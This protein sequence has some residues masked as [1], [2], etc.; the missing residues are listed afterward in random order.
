MTES[1][2]R[3][4]IFG[5]TG[6][7]GSYLSR[8]LLQQGYQVH[9]TSRDCAPANLHRLKHLNVLQ[10]V[11]VHKVQPTNMKIVAKVIE[12]VRPTEIYNLA[13]ES[14]VAVSFNKPAETLASTIQ[15]TVNMLEGMRSVGLDA[16]FYNAA[17]SECYG[18]T[19]PQG[20]D[21]TT[22]FSPRSPYGVGKAAAFWAVK[23][24]RQ[25]Y[26][27]FACSGILFNHESPL[28]PEWFVSQKIVRG[29]VDISLKNTDYL[30]LGDLTVARDWGWAPEYMEAVAKML[31]LDEPDDF[32]VAT[33][34]MARLETLVDLVFSYLNL[35]WTDHVISNPTLRRPTDISTSLGKPRKARR[36]LGWK[37]RVLLDEIV[38][39]LVEGELERRRA[40]L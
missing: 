16:K 1:D 17:S 20:A 28:R 33:G 5:I 36:V 26:N 24:Y 29:A 32:V 37:A 8:H 10:E 31:Q 14:S 30:E 18:N 23:N 4:L 9:G 13:S 7:D 21:E 19:G 40:A 35:S 22:P 38:E 15:A 3:A 39:K 34:K 25:A 6:Q 2:K 12:D 27:L 11:T